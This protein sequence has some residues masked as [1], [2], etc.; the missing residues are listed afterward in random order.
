[1]RAL[2]KTCQVMRKVDSKDRWTVEIKGQKMDD[3]SV[4]MDSAGLVY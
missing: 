4:E 3:L 1:M 2:E